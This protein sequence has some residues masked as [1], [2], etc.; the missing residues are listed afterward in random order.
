MVTPPDPPDTERRHKAALPVVRVFVSSPGD[1]AE[2]RNYVTDLVEEFGRRPSVSERAVLQCIRWDDP[3]AKIPLVANLS[4]QEAVDSWLPPPRICDLVIGIIWARMGTPLPDTIRKPDG[5][6]FLSGTEWEIEDALRDDANRLVM[7]YHRLDDPPMPRDRA[8]VEKSLVQRDAVDAFVERLRGRKTGKPRYVERYSGPAAFRAILAQHFE[9][10]IYEAIDRRLADNQPPSAKPVFQRNPYPGLKAFRPNDAPVFCGRDD[11]IAQLVAKILPNDPLSPFVAVIG[12]SGSG[13]SSLVLAGLIPRLVQDNW[14][15]VDLRLSSGD[16]LR[17]FAEKFA[18]HL[19]GEHQSDPVDLAEEW[20]RQPETVNNCVHHILGKNEA[21]GLLIVIDQ[22]EEILKVD[23]GRLPEL[24]GLLDQLREATGVRLVATLRAD[25][26][27]DVMQLGDLTRWMNGNTFLVE[28]PGPAALARIV[29]EPAQLA[30]YTVEPELEAQLLH[31]AGSNEGTLPI[32]C[33]TLHRIVGLA[34]EDRVLRIPEDAGDSLLAWAIAGEV[35]EVD[36]RLGPEGVAGLARLFGKLVSVSDERGDT[37][38]RALVA[39]LDQDLQVIVDTLVE[40]RF[41]TRIGDEGEEVELAHEVLLKAWPAL[42][43]WIEAF[44]GHLVIREEIRR[45][46]RRWEKAEQQEALLLPF[47]LVAE[48]LRQKAAG[49]ELLDK[50]EDRFLDLSRAARDDFW[51][52]ES[53]SLAERAKAENER[54]DHLTAVL[55]ALEGLPVADGEADRPLT[56]A[57]FTEL[58][59]GEGQCR[60]RLV[61]QTDD[62]CTSVAFSPDGQRLATG[63]WDKTVRVW[64]LVTGAE[65]LRLRGHEDWVTSV[66]FAPNGQR[67]ATG[68]DDGTVR[69]WDA[70]TGIEVL[71]LEGHAGDVAI[72]AFSTDGRRLATG[73]KDNTARVW[74]LGTGAEVSR[75]E[76]HENGVSSVA[77][78]PDGQHLA[79][80]SRDNTAR[81]WDLATGTKVLWVVRHDDTVSSV[82]FSPD[83]QRLATGSYDNTARVW[84]T[85]SGTEV[86]RLEGHKRSVTSVAFSPDGQHLATGS[87]DETARVWDAATGTEVLRLD[88]HGSWISSVAFSPDGESL[89]TGSKDSTA[90]VWDLAPGAEI[91]LLAGHENKVTSVVFSPDGQ[92]LTTGSEDGT[93]R[94]WDLAKGTETLRLTGHDGGVT[95]VA[96]S[97]PGQHLATGSHDG[98]ARLWDL[99]TGTEVLRFEGHEN[100]IT[101]VAFSP[102]GQ[103]L[104]TG[105]GDSTARVWDLVTGT[106]TLR[107]E[108]GPAVRVAFAPDGRRLFTGS[109]DGTAWVWDLAT[110]TEVLRLAGHENWITSVDFSPDGQRLATGSYDCT[111]RI[112]DAA[113]GIEMVQLERHENGVTCVAFS[114]DGRHLATASGGGT[115]RVWDLA[116]GTELLRLVGHKHPATSVAFSPDGRRLAVG[117]EDKI[118]RV[119]PM[120]TGGPLDYIEQVRRSVPRQLTDDQRAR[121]HLPPRGGRG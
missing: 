69:I 59:L 48:G 95:S 76:G 12:N 100:W 68:S 55:L 7:I 2:E 92:R 54:G 89:A 104:A 64:D 39:G 82:A 29:R 62:G 24:L 57:A 40:R 90:R 22:F 72:I 70:A 120:F 107:F 74:D 77:F 33:L 110:R 16:P 60:E 97:P 116:S 26:L 14:V 73:S 71:R 67:L 51:L 66:A 34:K 50:E 31:E 106:E 94:V 9:R 93:A 84:E 30:G 27:G 56:A 43:D 119:Y 121:F 10:L 28:P 32:L 42:R 102:D 47:W 18:L 38:R 20:L 109:S 88:G 8:E 114:P 61:L 36:R 65:V 86:L 45:Q 79:T 87:W 63:S 41:L 1:V 23:A 96:F 37:K 81:V 3:Q 4:P 35:A 17:P 118:A 105:S 44:R 25:K 13:K 91:R 111:A 98:T 113:T 117:S 108:D 112:W 46:W 99:A 52:R 49:P 101:S 11:L 80:G 5:S 21:P 15:A 83:G 103:R 58:V 53:K 85:A 115:A 6:P 19:P 75:L 78:S